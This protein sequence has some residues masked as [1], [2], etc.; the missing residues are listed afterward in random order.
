MK[1]RHSFYTEMLKCAKNPI[2]YSRINYI[3]ACYNEELYMEKQSRQYY[4][5]MGE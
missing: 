3:L 2:L 1:L 4:E 5:S